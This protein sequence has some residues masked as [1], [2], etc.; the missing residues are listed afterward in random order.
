MGSMIPCSSRLLAELTLGGFS[1]GL[2]LPVA[3]LFCSNRNERCMTSFLSG[4]HATAGSAGRCRQVI[5]HRRCG[6]TRVPFVGVPVVPAAG[7]W[8]A[9]C[10]TTRLWKRSDLVLAASRHVALLGRERCCA[11][12]DAIQSILTT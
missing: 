9:C 4:T 8:A 10:A 3:E 5:T 11:L 6:L 1:L 12:A 2:G 7:A